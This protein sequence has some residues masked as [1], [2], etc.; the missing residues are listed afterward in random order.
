MPPSREIIG[1][2]PEKK[3]CF[4]L[5]T[6]SVQLTITNTF[7]VAYVMENLLEFNQICT[8]VEFKLRKPDF[9]G[10]LYCPAAL[11][12]CYMDSIATNWGVKLFLRKDFMR[13]QV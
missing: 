5:A 9:N 6:L 2:F 10:Y 8:G 11:L 1:H 4:I 12:R 7:K 13:L 3:E